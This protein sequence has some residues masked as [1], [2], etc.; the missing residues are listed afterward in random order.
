MGSGG[1][2][3]RKGL[4]LPRLLALCRGL[5]W[6]HL[7]TISYHPHNASGD[8]DRLPSFCR[9]AVT[10]S[11]EITGA[12]ELSL[13]PLP[14]SQLPLPDPCLS[15]LSGWGLQATPTSWG[16]CKGQR[17]PSLPPRQPRHWGSL[18]SYSWGKAALGEQGRPGA[19]DVWAVAQL[20]ASTGRACV[21]PLMLASR[22]A[23]LQCACLSLLHLCCH[24]ENMPGLVPGGRR[25]ARRA[26]PLRH[27]PT[28][29][30]VSQSSRRAAG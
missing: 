17:G 29:R 9:E 13:Q 26:D 19:H 25:Q 20:P 8:S 10:D 18:H 12:L 11:A 3:K 6:A 4:A 24:H 15:I 14:P 28:P 27:Q 21:W 30:H 5:Y 1:N 2:P 23:D 22:R 7:R 16:P